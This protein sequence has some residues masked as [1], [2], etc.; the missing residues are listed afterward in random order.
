VAARG[1]EGIVLSAIK[2]RGA[3]DALAKLGRKAG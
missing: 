2:P 3:D 1:Y